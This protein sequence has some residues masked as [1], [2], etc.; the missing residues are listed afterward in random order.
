MKN[1]KNVLGRDLQLCSAE[2]KTGYLRS[3]TCETGPHDLG[4]HVVCAQ[5]TQR[6][7]EFTRSRGN[8]LSTPIPGSDFPGLRPGDRWCLCALRWKEAL[9]AGVAPPVILSAT[10]EAV[11]RHVPI[12]DLKRHALPEN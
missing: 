10:H 9:K 3:G 11:L 4:S 7:L 8:D 6:F 12:E 5:V 1:T 2:P